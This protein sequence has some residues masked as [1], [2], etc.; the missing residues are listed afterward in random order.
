MIAN[1]LIDF[2]IFFCQNFFRNRFRNVFDHLRLIDLNDIAFPS[3]FS[4]YL[5]QIDLIIRTGRERHH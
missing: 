1:L 5:F 2:S 4:S 3:S